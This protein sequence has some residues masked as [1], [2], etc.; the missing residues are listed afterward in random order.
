MMCTLLHGAVVRVAALGVRGHGFEFPN[1]P[2]TKQVIF[3]DQ[4][5]REQIG[6]RPIP[7][8]LP[9]KILEK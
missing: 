7:K 5:V 3:D 8:T 4:L 1:I 9:S 6:Y 2:S